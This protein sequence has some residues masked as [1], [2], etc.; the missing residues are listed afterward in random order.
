MIDPY[1]DDLEQRIQPE[2]E[3]QLFQEWTDFLDGGHRDNSVFA[4][5]RPQSVPPGIA[6]P[7]ININDALEDY[8]LM[9]LQQL[10]TCSEAL[11]NG[12]G[13]IL[14]VRCNYGTGIIPTMFGA[15]L[16]VMPRD[17]NTL[18]TN[19]PLEGGADAMKA[20]LDRDVPDIRNGLGG[21][22]F[23]MAQCFQNMLRPYP[24]IQ[25]YIHLYHPD[26]Q[27]PMDICELLWGSSLFVALMDIPDLV[28]AV[29]ELI[30]TIYM[31]VMQ[32][33]SEQVPFKNEYNVHWSLLH[34]GNIMLRDDSAMNLSPKMFAEFVEPYDQRLLD[35]FGGGA[36]HFCGKGDHYI[37]RIS[38][39]RGVYAVQMSQ[40]E[41]NDMEKIFTHTIDKGIP[42]LRLPPE[43]A[44]AALQQGRD[45]HG[46][47]HCD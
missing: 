22:V 37:A 7:D 43:A 34:K 38:E 41:Y 26:T 14:A 36:L 2:I 24:K 8:E 16:F 28:K 45:L 6:W 31:R 9:A 32:A 18:P 33:W 39:M 25:R 30:T 13:D 29:L 47:V 21:K 17:T 27:G 5:R 4:P 44:Q 3:E 20:L 40:P 12:T 1:L 23:E 42:L 15:E 46:L 11:T 35:E 19:R 10:K